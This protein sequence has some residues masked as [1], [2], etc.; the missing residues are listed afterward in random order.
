VV[1]LL[2][3]DVA[4]EPVLFYIECT[5]TFLGRLRIASLFK[6]LDVIGFPHSIK[7]FLS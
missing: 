4:P 3:L 5:F 6:G 7:E 2:R 1:K